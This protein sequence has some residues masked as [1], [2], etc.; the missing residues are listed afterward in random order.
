MTVGKHSPVLTVTVTVGTSVTVT[1]GTTVTVG[2]V[3]PLLVV[4]FLVLG[5][6]VVRRWHL[7]TISGPRSN[8]TLLPHHPTTPP[9]Y[10][11]KTLPP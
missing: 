7:R 9:P 1:V 10:H 4:A 8:T 3:V 6:L 2:G 11:P 5:P